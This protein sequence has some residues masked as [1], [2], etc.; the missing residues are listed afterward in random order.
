MAART[1][2]DVRPGEQ[3]S[4][5][6]HAFK[7]QKSSSGGDSPKWRDARDGGWFEYQLRVP[8]S[9]PAELLVTYWGS[10]AGNRQFDILVD[11]QKIAT[12]KLEGRRPNE[13]LE[14]SYAVPP[15]L[16]QGKSQVTIRFQAHPGN[17]AGGVFGLR[18]LKP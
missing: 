8:G 13:H 17:F 5:V 15:A 7:G 18:V 14:Q 4:E 12:E 16:T 1:V 6:D 9:Q 2:D 10:D 11:G 3:Q